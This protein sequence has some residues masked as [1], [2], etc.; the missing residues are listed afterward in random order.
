MMQ[1]DEN[2]EKI[3]IIFFCHG[4]LNFGLP[5]SE[6]NDMKHMC[7]LWKEKTQFLPT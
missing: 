1:A 4:N 6:N 2:S 3:M 5:S 7:I